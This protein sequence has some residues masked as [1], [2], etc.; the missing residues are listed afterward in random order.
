MR[1]E[2]IDGPLDKAAQ[3][4]Q[5][6]APALLERIAA[7]IKSSMQSVRP[8]PPTWLLTAAL[9]FIC[10]AIGLAG[11]LHAGF[12]GIEKMDLWQR[13]LIF[14]TLAIF[15]H[16]AAQEFV[17]EF[18]PG[19]RRRLSAGALLAAGTAALLAVFALLFRDYQTTHFLSAGIVCLA[20]GLLHAIP[21]GL[22]AWLILRRG[23]ALNK[24]TAGVAG[25]TLAG[26]AG[27]F[28]LELHCSNFQATHIL[29]WHSAVIPLAASAGALLAYGLP[30]PKLP[31]P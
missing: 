15:A 17:A 25:G 6:V 11:A 8:L 31:N 14:T 2:R 4:P 12:Y 29:I 16:A 7:S 10:A 30:T 27:V 19:S 13:I 3:A 9:V 5:E 21:A 18:I 1:D 20:V 24:I 22:I 28:M 23:F 26:L